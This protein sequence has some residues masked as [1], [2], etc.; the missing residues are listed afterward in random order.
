MT[1][2][3]RHHPGW[4]QLPEAAVQHTVIEM[5]SYRQPA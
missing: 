3:G 2:Y 5:D 4:V 1:G